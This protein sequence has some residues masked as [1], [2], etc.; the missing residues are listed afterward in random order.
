MLTAV[1]DVGGTGR[2]TLRCPLIYT[3][4][5]AREVNTVRDHTKPQGDVGLTPCVARHAVDLKGACNR[6]EGCYGWMRGCLEL[7]RGEV[8][9]ASH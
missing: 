9:Q 8:I 4:I 7:D 6:S 1:F 2:A 5:L 3:F